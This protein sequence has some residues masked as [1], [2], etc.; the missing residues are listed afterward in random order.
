MA[1]IEQQKLLI[2]EA[3]NILEEF[4]I[5]DNW[6]LESIVP[7]IIDN[8]EMGRDIGLSCR[9]GNP[10]LFGEEKRET[11]IVRINHCGEFEKLWRKE[12]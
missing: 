1:N 12:N 5:S 10:N 6:R 9:I 3:A 11:Y 7:V 2:R 4:G 8:E